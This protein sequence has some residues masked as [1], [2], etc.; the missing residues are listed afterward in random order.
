MAHSHQH[1]DDHDQ[2]H[3][4]GHSH[5]HSH[6]H[7]HAGHSHAPTSFGTAFAVGV[8]LNTAFVI[9]ELVFGYA[10]NSLALI[11]DAIHNLSDVMSLLLAWGALWL[12]GRRPT[13]RHTYGYRRASILAAL[14]NAGLLL[15]VVGG[16]AVEA[17]D[18]LRNPG[19]VAGVTVLW[20]A[21]LGIVINGATAM[22]FM[23]GR[24]SDLNIRGA[25]LHMAADAAVSFGVVVA[26]A[27]TIWTG[28]LWVDPVVSLVIALVVLLSGWELARD[29]VNLALDAVP[30]DIALP[31]VRDY[32]AS[33]DGVSEVHDLHVWAM[34]TNE[35]ALTAHLV[36]PDGTDDA[37]LHKVCAELS[38]RFKIQHSTLQIEA[39]GKPCK[40]A[41]ADVV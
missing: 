27:I 21:A 34:S 31:E 1:H 22:L 6:S 32:L 24:D 39:D 13:D 15:L 33:L 28:W 29:S 25:Y 17:F 20:V 2:D 38:R 14:I 40:L 30:R 3:L 9:A 37:F 8:S 4:H 19:E 18:R 11:S 36:C 26:A 7:S 5:A 35:T 41:P 16:I 23:R 10:A 12:S